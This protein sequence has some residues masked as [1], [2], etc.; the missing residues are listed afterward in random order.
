MDRAR[1]H[2]ALLETLGR[3]VRTR[4]TA[5]GWTVRELSSR[6]RVSERFLVQLEGGQGNIS[7]ARLHDVARAL[8]TTAAELLAEHR[9]PL[10]N[11]SQE[12]KRVLA[13]L[14]LRGAGKTTIGSKAA[15]RL[16]IPFVELDALVEQK[17][18]MSLAE[19][20]EL[21]GTEYYR[22]I[23]R[24]AL[25]DFLASGERAVLAT[26]GGIVTD[27]ETYELLR[28]ETITVWLKARPEEHLA[29]VISQGDVRPMQNRSDAMSDIR[30]LLLT[31]APLYR[32]ADVTVDTSALGLERSV[33]AVVRAARQLA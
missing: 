22:R 6:A 12:G 29:R 10:S 33:R 8:G 15:E 30:K 16:G 24:Q 18:G 32:K 17:T 19:L 25:V 27:H 14:G 11:G 4:R 21:H 28:R 13:L 5:L 2:K 23:E 31:R 3:Q 26:G 20:F 9:S 1:E 7:V